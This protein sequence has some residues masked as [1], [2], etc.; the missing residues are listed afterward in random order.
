MLRPLRQRDFALLWTAMTVSMLGDGLYLVA[1]AWLAYDRW[2]GASTLAAFGAGWTGAQALPL[3]PTGV[4]S[5]R[6]DRRS[7][8]IASDAIR[9]LAIGG[10]ALLTALDMAEVWQIVVLVT[11]CGAG[12]ALFWPAF[13]A[14]VP[15]IVPPEHL[16]E[17]NALDHFVRPLA[18]QLAGPPLGG[19]PV[20]SLGV[21]PAFTLDAASSACSGLVLLLLRPR[22]ITRAGRRASAV[23]EA[24]DGLGWVRTQPWLWVGL[25][26]GA[27]FLL[28]VWG[29]FEVLVPG[30]I[31]EELHRSATQLGLVFAAGGL[32]AVLAALA[33]S[34]Q[35]LPRRMV[36]FMYAT[37]GCGLLM[38][39]G[40]AIVENAWQAMAISAASSALFAVAGV[41]WN[42]MRQ[43]L[44]PVELMGRVSSID[45]FVS[46]SL[47]P[48]SFIL[49]APLA[50]ALGLRGALAAAGL[51][52]ALLTAGVMLVPAV[53]EPER[54]GRLALP[55]GIDVAKAAEI[56]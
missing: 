17:A 48:V 30:L 14:L 31:K 2:G 56:R 33:I 47:A 28:V 23:R 20:G 44:V 49:A 26:W 5:D 54:D 42:T 45:G 39:A 24:L 19:V 4:L 27:L 15:Q 38:V 37:I 6:F 21:A 11:L 18:L 1:I 32:G 25:V 22:P 10:V 7:L 40:F 34:Q 3:L 43:R 13:A 36:S 46:V 35:G 16:V 12:E 53:R 29:P 51:V 55:Q 41:A 8:M 50:R 52:G 9:G